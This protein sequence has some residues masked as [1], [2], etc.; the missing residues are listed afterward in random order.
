MKCKKTFFNINK[1]PVKYTNSTKVQLK[2]IG[3][4]KQLFNGKDLSGWKH[5]GGGS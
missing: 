5:L 3:H 2:D 4:W 1:S